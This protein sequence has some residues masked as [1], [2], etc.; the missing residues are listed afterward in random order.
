MRRLALRGALLALISSANL[1]PGGPAHAAPV[2][3]N[4]AAA[5]SAAGHRVPTEFAFGA[6]GFGT[7]IRG[8]DIPVASGDTAWRATG[9]TNAAGVDKS[10]EEAQV[11]IPGL[12]TIN[13]L[14]TRVWTTKHG[15]RYASHAS[16]E[17]ANITLVES[18]IGSLALSG[19]K[20][21]AHAIHSPSGYHT[22]TT[23]EVLKLVL[24]PPVGDPI[25]IPI[26]APGDVINV[27][28]FPLRI[29][30]GAIHE[31]TGAHSATARASGLLV[32]LTQTHTLVRI[33]SSRARIAEGVRK[34][35]F[36]GYSD[37]LSATAL[38][39]G[40]DSIVRVGRTPLMTM[41]C[42][43]TDGLI[44]ERPTV[45]VNIPGALVVGAVTTRQRGKQTNRGGRGFEEAKIASV[46]LGDQ[47]QIDAITARV[48]V[49][50]KGRKVIRNIKGT[51]ALGITVNGETQTIPPL[52]VLEIPGLVKIEQNVVERTRNSIGVIAL[53][54]TL[55]DGTGAVVNLGEAKL[56]IARS[57]H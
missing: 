37:G 2:V 45:G 49:I 43:G 8:G 9:C 27:P 34:G 15:H 31:H 29:S 32:T 7:R 52:G 40:D 23:A 53:R 28:G 10:N 55:L 51:S 6:S 26:P 57:V 24:T 12:G 14:K 46:N 4:N 11:T 21:T 19:I 47:I 56:K 39:V 22:R 16:H 33:A 5:E 41:P 36:S 17:I 18:A 35:L 54:L 20:T 50:R 1:L 30:M 13:G 42:Q 48:N 25:E 38:N 3:L 44:K